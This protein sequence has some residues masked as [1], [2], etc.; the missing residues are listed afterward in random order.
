MREMLERHLLLM[1]QR[2]TMRT[3]MGTVSSFL[4]FSTEIVPSSFSGAIDFEEFMTVMKIEHGVLAQSLWKHYDKNNDSSI[5]FREASFPCKGLGSG[6]MSGSGS[7]L[8]SRPGL[9]NPAAYGHVHMPAAMY[10][11]LPPC[12]ARTISNNFRSHASQT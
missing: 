2:S 10:T 8:G 1:L 7:G 5:D 9:H 6:S 3:W 4:A 11:C 12:A